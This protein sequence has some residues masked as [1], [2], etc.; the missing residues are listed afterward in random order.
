MARIVRLTESDLNRIVRRV[1]KE[2]E[3]DFRTGK[4]DQMRE[5]KRLEDAQNYINSKLDGVKKV[6]SLRYPRS[7]F[8]KKD[9]E[10]LFEI[11][12]VPGEQFWFGPDNEPEVKMRIKHDLWY[13]VKQ[14]FKIMEQE[15]VGK[16]FGNWVLQNLDLVGGVPTSI[17]F[18]APRGWDK[19][20]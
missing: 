15:K 17:W 3:Y 7:L 14:M 19:D 1:I 4:I 11:K 5:N 2:E 18:E 13:E 12:M 20:I 8:F 6:G 10:I 9:G 16:L